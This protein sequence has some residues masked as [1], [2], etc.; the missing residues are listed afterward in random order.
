MLSIKR[1]ADAIGAAWRFLTGEADAAREAISRVFEDNFD[2]L[3][4]IGEDGR[5]IAASRV[6]SQLLL[7]SGNG[8]IVGRFAS[9]VLPE[10]MLKAVQQAFADGRRG[11]HR[12]KPAVPP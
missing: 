11:V 4:I 6:A 1:V 7:G 10:P 3:A 9:D 12:R 2:G 8:S 5:I